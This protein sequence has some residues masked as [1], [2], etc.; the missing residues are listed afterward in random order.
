V[1]P[2]YPPSM[3]EIPFPA[4]AAAAAAAGNG[5]SCIEGG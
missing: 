2:D 4:A 1:A 3:Q 5:I